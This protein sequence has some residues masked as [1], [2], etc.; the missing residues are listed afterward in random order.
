[1]AKVDLD[2][3]KHILQRNEIEARRVDSI[4]GDIEEEM[5]L[6]DAEKPPT[7]RVKKQFVVIVS[8]P[9]GELEG[10]DFTGWIVQIPED[11]TPLSAE[12]RVVRAAYEFNTTPKGRRMPV[13]T[14]AEACE[15]VPARL[16][17]EQQVWIKTKEPVYLLRTNNDIPFD[18]IKKK[19]NADVEA[20]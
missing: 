2:L 6:M 10:K 5:K 13:K 9:N 8:D 11:D 4:I 7:E 19:A 20:F 3:V 14:I 18:E 16:S 12:E 17:K 15:A 1:M